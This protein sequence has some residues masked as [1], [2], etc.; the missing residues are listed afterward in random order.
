MSRRNLSG[1]GYFHSSG[2]GGS[3][4]TW[5]ATDKNSGITLSGG[6]LTA[7][8]STTVNQL[9]RATTS[10]TTGKFYWENLINAASNL[11][12]GIANSSEVTGNYL[13][14]STNGIGYYNNNVVLRNNATVTN[15]ATFSA[16]NTV[17][18]AVDIGGGLIWWRVN[19]GNWNNNASANPATGTLGITYSITGAIF[20]AYSPNV[21]SDGITTAFGN[22]TRTP[23]SGFTNL[24]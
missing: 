6:N 17:D 24:P 20:P 7:H 21:T 8:A 18:I 9:G 16:T 10:E 11:G 19:N 12:V 1:K 23:P 3:S 5:S 4:T 22:F 13:G 14:V 2:G 15:L